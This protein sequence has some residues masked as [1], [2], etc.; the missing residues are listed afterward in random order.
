MAAATS[1]RAG[2]SFSSDTYLA[3]LMAELDRAQISGRIRRA[4]KESGYRSQKELGDV[5]HV[6][7]RTV[8]DW[9]NEKSG[10]VPFDRLDEIAKATDKSKFWLLHGRDEP[11][12]EGDAAATKEILR[13]LEGLEARVD[14]SN[15]LT[16]HALELLELLVAPPTAAAPPTRKRASG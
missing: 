7:W 2:R 3:S 5:L 6:H 8:Q 1:P 10:N 16:R 15:G 12:S 11:S 13:R 9:E 4:R 14:E